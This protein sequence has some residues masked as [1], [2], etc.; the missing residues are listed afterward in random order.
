VENLDRSGFTMNVSLTGAFIRTNNVYPPGATLKTE[1][2]FEDGPVTVRAR[3]V[4]AK[5]VPREMAHL[6]K[7]GMG[8]R[9]VNPGPEWTELFSGWETKKAGG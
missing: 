4:W 9:F 2:N 5:K 6:L 7:C 8:V 1:F 3:V